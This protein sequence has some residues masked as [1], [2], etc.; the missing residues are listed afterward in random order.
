[1]TPNKKEKRFLPFDNEFQ[2]S[3]IAQ[4]QSRRDINTQAGKDLPKS[5]MPEKKGE[6]IL[7]TFQWADPGQ[8]IRQTTFPSP[9]P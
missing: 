5:V 9:H 3:V 6:G 7:R 4:A 1:L 8:N 2:P